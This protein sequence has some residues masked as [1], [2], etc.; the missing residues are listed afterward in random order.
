M[1]RLVEKEEFDSAGERHFPQERMDAGAVALFIGEAP[2]KAN[3]D[4]NAHIEKNWTH[5]RKVLEVTSVSRD[6]Y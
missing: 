5:V 2:D 3:D 6:R 1:V 4:D